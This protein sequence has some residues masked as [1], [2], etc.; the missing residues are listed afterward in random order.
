MT[1][2]R[3]LFAEGLRDHLAPA[4]RAMGFTGWRRSFSLPDVDHWALLGIR[5]GHADDRVVRYTVVLAVTP[6]SAW[7]GPG[8]RPDPATATGRETWRSGI[9]ELMPVGG[10]VWWQVAPGPRWQVGLED[11][12]AAVRHYGLPELLRRVEQGAGVETYLT[13]AELADVNAALELAEVPRIRR[14]ELAD[15]ALELHGAWQRADVVAEEV[16]RGAATG[17]LSAGDERFTAVRCRDTRGREL[18]VFPAG[19]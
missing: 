14:A 13:Q 1:T 17:F 19:R 5:L 10:E 3:T 18:W 2:A 11:T 8:L 12:V 7:A 4:L 6:K 16:L 15:K 9:G